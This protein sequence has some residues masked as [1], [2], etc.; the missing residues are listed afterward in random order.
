MK[1]SFYSI[2]LLGTIIYSCTSKTNIASSAP[3]LSHTEVVAQGKTI[4]DA[5]CGKCHD[6]PQP[7]DHTSQEWDKIIERMAPKAKLSPEETNWV[8]AY[9]KA[10][11]KK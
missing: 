9:V 8:L 10:D 11:A 7:S 3:N 2:A 5:R 4:F 1:K 6:L